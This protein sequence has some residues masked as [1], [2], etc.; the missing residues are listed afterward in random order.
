[1]NLVVLVNIFA[2]N[3]DH[4]GLGVGEGHLA[5]GLGGADTH[6][7]GVE[8]LLLVPGPQE[9]FEVGLTGQRGNALLVLRKRNGDEFFFFVVG[10]HKNFPLLEVGGVHR[11]VD[12]TLVLD[13]VNELLEGVDRAHGLHGFFTDRQSLLIM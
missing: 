11:H 7:H 9:D 12:L 6:L 8:A 5:D 1:M 2:R 3:D 10:G 4:V 13:H